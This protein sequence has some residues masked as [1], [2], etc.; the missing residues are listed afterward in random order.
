MICVLQGLQRRKKSSTRKRLLVNNLQTGL[1]HIKEFGIYIITNEGS[2]F[3]RMQQPKF[4]FRITHAA[5]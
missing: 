2:V 5:K 3:P 1:A 4:D